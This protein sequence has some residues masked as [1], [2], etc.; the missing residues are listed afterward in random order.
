MTER[1]LTRR[2]VLAAGSAGALA[3]T[4]GCVGEGAV[5]GMQNGA[6]NPT[7]AV[8]EDRSGTFALTGTAKYRATK[9]AIEE[10]NRDGGILGEELE[11]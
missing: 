3:A 6:S 5:L 10:I 4:A 7:A 9:L 2:S 8:L 1:S 11:V